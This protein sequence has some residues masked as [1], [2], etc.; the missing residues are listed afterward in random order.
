MKSLRS[1]TR[2]TISSN[3]NSYILSINLRAKSNIN[4]V[5]KINKCFCYFL[6]SPYIIFFM[7]FQINKLPTTR[8]FQINWRKVKTHKRYMYKLCDDRE[9]VLGWQRVG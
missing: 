6:T 9:L 7:F 5:Q 1:E 4:I 3:W 2:G 8:M